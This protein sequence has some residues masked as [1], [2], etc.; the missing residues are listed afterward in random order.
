MSNLPI[1]QLCYVSYLSDGLDAE[2]VV[3]DI[4][5]VSSVKNK[6]Y[7]LTGQLVYSQ[8]VFIQIL[9]GDPLNVD[10][11]YRIIQS[12]DRH[13][14]PGILFEQDTDSRSFAK[15][16]MKFHSVKSIDLAQINRALK[17][18]TLAKSKNYFTDEEIHKLFDDFIN[19]KS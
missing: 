7:N 12:D 8:E 1:K 10:I 19:G 17:V 5:K 11:T 2:T 16:S 9:E 18:A 15:W 13:I 4:Q 14:N 3:R 6:K